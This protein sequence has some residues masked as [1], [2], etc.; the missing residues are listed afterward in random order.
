MPRLMGMQHSVSLPAAAA[1]AM[2]PESEVRRRPSLDPR[3]AGGSSQH[4]HHVPVLNN[5]SSSGVGSLTREMAAEG[6][7]LNDDLHE[8]EGGSGPERMQAPP[9]NQSQS[10]SPLQ[11]WRS[12]LRSSLD[13]LRA[14]TAE[15]QARQPAESHSRP[16]QPTNPA[17][18]QHITLQPAGSVHQALFFLEPACICLGSRQKHKRL[19]R[20]AE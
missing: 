2:S 15:L 3:E 18:S 1:E 11:A 20:G 14:V 19:C 10:G 7:P 5:R 16:M 4:L 13:R 8:G 12:R 9:E 6:S 17:A